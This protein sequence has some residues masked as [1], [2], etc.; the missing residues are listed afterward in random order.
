MIYYFSGTGNSKAVAQII[1][2]SLHTT[3][4]QIGASTISDDDSIGIVVPVYSWGIPPIVLQWL[5]S[6]QHNINSD[7]Y[8]WVIL[9][10][11][12]ESGLAHEMLAN[13]MKRNGMHIDAMFGITMPNTYVLLP[14]FN[15]DAKEVSESKLRNMLPRMREIAT[16]INNRQT[17]IAD[18]HIG[19][20][21]WLK[22]KLIYPLFK[23]AGISPSKWKCV[24][25]K[26]VSCGLCARSCPVKN[27]TI[28]N[29]HPTW[30]KQCTSC[31]GCYH[32]CPRHA[33]E[34]GTITA[35]KGQWRHW[36]K[37]RPH[38]SETTK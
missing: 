37:N 13:V 38:L 26:C 30:G 7:T 34:Y 2:T 28:N 36:F 32:S 25:G 4:E 1:A 16:C 5:T 31:L 21:A 14:G 8:V 17:N 19:K 15:I 6:V 20:L 18:I 11:G 3:A 27:I 12:D 22:T 23:L 9:T 29:G 24:K 35:N 10:Y 33:I